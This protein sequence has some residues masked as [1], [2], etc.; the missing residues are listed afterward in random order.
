MPTLV[1]KDPTPNQPE[2][3]A[4]SRAES[5]VQSYRDLV[6]RVVASPT[7][8][9]SERLSALLAFVC[10]MAFTGRQA[11]LNEQRIGQ[12][13]FGRSPEYDSSADGIVRTQASRLRQ[14]LDLFF[15]QEGCQEPIRITIPKGGYV[16]RFDSRQV[17]SDLSLER[18]EVQTTEIGD[19]PQP[20]ADAAP[21]ANYRY[22]GWLRWLLCGLMAATL[23]VL[24]TGY[25]AR[26]S[27]TG[28][29]AHPLWGRIFL[30]DRP[31]LEVPGDSGLVL[32]YLVDKRNV[33]LHDY[34]SGEYRT[35]IGPAE[36][37]SKLD[38]AALRADFVTRPYTSIVDLE[39]AVRLG[40]LAQEAHSRLQVRYTR[41]IRPNDLKSQNVILIG[42]REANPW[43]E[44]FE[45][46]M[47]FL[48]QDDFK[49]AFAV[50]NKMPH[51]GEPSRWIS[52]AEDPEHRVYG[53][54]AF[55]P[56]VSGDGNAL[57]I[58]GTSM[59]GTEA[60]WDFVSDDVALLPFLKRIRRSDGS[61]PH[62]EIVVG[63]Q[64]MNA[65]ALHDEL[66]AWRVTD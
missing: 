23:F 53:I 50:L 6:G 25:R 55:T 56:N 51:P 48:L 4:H 11:E 15:E 26:S 44:L 35:R 7:F 32:S 12:S 30:P 14:R 13:V 20:A 36:G 19:I 42:A 29:A 43:V 22:L 24:G 5:A 21:D 63:T 52:R 59:A 49:G 62:F 41:D 46:R 61:I 37:A 38:L 39:V 9:R 54:V 3:V 34:L 31:T 18:D 1:K 58:E 8:A 60:A 65:S 66:L 27:H 10:E 45:H 47:N 17:V 16:P 28:T 33:S 40:Q 57:L 64:N 2:L